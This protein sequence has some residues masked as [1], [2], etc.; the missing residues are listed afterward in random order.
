[1]VSPLYTIAPSVSKPPAPARIYT[2]APSTKALVD[3]FRQVTV[4]VT[5]TANEYLFAL[6][7]Y[8][9]VSKIVSVEP[10]PYHIEIYKDMIDKLGYDKI[11][12]VEGAAADEKGKM[13][14][15]INVT[16]PTM[17]SLNFV[18][19]M[20]YDKQIEVNTYSMTDLIEI[21]GYDEVDFVKLDIE[22]GEERVLYSNDFK[23]AAKK[24]KSIYVEVHQGLGSNLQNVLYRLSE[25]GF[26]EIFLTPYA[27]NQGVYAK[28]S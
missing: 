10:T 9:K 24:I 6:F 27:P 2:L 13:S 12:I 14:F 11:S 7:I 25:V 17:N 26:D 15:F 22:G 21:A 19:E 28:K 1:L 4:Q 5:F 8:P 16:N 20:G 3:A 18:K 23:K